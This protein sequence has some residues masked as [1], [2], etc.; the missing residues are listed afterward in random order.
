MNNQI[1][2]CD[3]CNAC[4]HQLC[5]D[6]A[7]GNEFVSD[8]ARSW[9]CRGCLAKRERSH[10]GPRKRVSNEGAR[11]VSW[12]GRSP[13]KRQAYLRGLPRQELLNLLLYS[14]ELHPDLP[15]FP[16]G[17]V[18]G[19]S[20]TSGPGLF[21]RGGPEGLFLRA[22]AS[23]GG[24]MNFVRKV[25]SPSTSSSQQNGNPAT[26]SAASQ[27]LPD[28]N[29]SAEQEQEDSDDVPP[30][31]PKVGHGVLDTAGIKLRDSDFED[32]DDYEAFSVMTF[33]KQG[34]KITENGKP[35][36]K[37]NDGERESKVR[38]ELS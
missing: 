25:S 33:D 12:A 30:A 18:N 19:T 5:H 35:V 24:Q 7:I 38:N 11:G 21:A 14:V 22:E 13:E 17:E 34:R 32:N 29:N 27:N 10:G 23:N 6:P 37:E 28:N 9:F 36:T 16:T 15:I 3:G 1:V 20:R 31:W 8:E 2:F 4:W 26:Q